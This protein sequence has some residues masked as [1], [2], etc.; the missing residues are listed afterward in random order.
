VGDRGRDLKIAILSDVDQFDLS[1]PAD[2]LDEVGTNAAAMAKDVDKATDELKRL[3]TQGE[4]AQREL[5][6]LSQE[7]KNN[8]LDKLSHDAKDTASKVDSSFEKIAASSKSNL[9]KVDAAAKDAG[10]GLH[11]LKDEAGSS[12]KEAAAS[13]SG[14]FDDITGFV[15][16]TAA[17]AFG[18]FGAMGA[19]AGIAGAIGIGVIGSAIQAAKE[20]VKELSNAFR[21]AAIDGGGFGASVKVVL[22]DLK[23]NGRLVDLAADAKRL[24]IDWGTLIRAMA[25]SDS[26][27][28]SV[29]DKLNQLGASGATAHVNFNEAANSYDNIRA[30]LGLTGEAMDDATAAAVAYSDGIAATTIQ[31]EAAKE[32]EDK[33]QAALDETIPI[34]E[35][36]GAADKAR[37]DGTA[38]SID[39]VIRK[40]EEEIASK[41]DF[42]KNTKA[43]LD[44]VGQDGV[45]WANSFG[46]LAPQM[47][48][49]LAA[50]PKRK[51]KEIVRNFATIG[52]LAGEGTADALAAKGAKVASSAVGV[53][54]EASAAVEA[55][56]A[57]G[58]KLG[59]AGMDIPYAVR[60]QMAEAQQYAN[61]H[62]IIL[63]P[64]RPGGRPIRDVP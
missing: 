16:E 11:N 28:V 6:R 22:D 10:E 42:L 8:D 41:R 37:A 20:R 27:L 54:N 35:A 61:D 47:M 18:G 58:I 21:D 32:A 24:G 7:A 1:K 40:Q 56:G 48:A 34:L 23:D 39:Q 4:D 36:V 30:S 45:D 33:R 53:Y 51:Q 2:Q 13:F 5:D 59:L 31:T 50:A 17:N 14:G 15:Q 55:L 52:G 25:G 3:A 64:A 12:G 9:H 29:T 63:P 62:P 49:E 26:D 44:E 38:L 60:L 46:E 57:I 43:V 19:A